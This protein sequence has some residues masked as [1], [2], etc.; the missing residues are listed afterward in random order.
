VGGRDEQREARQA[1]EAGEKGGEEEGE[2]GRKVLEME[3]EG[4]GGV[5]REVAINSLSVSAY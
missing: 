5:E 3:D 1:R 2:R 4:S